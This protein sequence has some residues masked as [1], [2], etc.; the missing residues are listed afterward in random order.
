M[1]N[2]VNNGSYL[3]FLVIKLDL[4]KPGTYSAAT[5]SGSGLSGSVPGLAGSRSGRN[6][7]RIRLLPDLNPVAAGSKVLHGLYNPVQALA[8]RASALLHLVLAT[9]FLRQKY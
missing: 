3:I 1:L 6:R 4:A 7:V 8:F 9:L 5:G 2:P